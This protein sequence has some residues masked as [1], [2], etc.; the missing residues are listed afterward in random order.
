V[1]LAESAPEAGICDETTPALADQGG[2]DELRRFVQQ[3]AE[4]DL[5]HELIHQ[6][7]RL[8]L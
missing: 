3:K 2:T 6:C 4:Q 8:A 7:Q 1:E 5:F